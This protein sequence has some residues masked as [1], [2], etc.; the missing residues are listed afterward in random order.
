MKNGI[1]CSTLLPFRKSI[2]RNGALNPRLYIFVCVLVCCFFPQKTAG[3]G[4]G[5]S[6]APAWSRPGPDADG[7]WEECKESE[8]PMGRVVPF[9]KVSLST[10]SMS[11]MMSMLSSVSIVTLT[12]CTEQQNLQLFRFRYDDCDDCIQCASM[13]TVCFRADASSGAIAVIVLLQR[14]IDGI[15][16][17][18]FPHVMGLV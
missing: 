8:P 14:A 10:L 16:A 7:G 1:F 11:C 4:G 5:P 15:N 9:C 12:E 13:R 6:G 3:N 18:I 17:E 2:L